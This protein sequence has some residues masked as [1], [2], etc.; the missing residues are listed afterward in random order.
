[1]IVQLRGGLELESLLIN[2]IKNNMN[3]V[4]TGSSLILKFIIG[5]T[6]LTTSKNEY[7]EIDRHSEQS[8]IGFKDS[9]K[10][11]SKSHDILRPD[12]FLQ[13]LEITFALIGNDTFLYGP[14]FNMVN[15]Y[16]ICSPMVQFRLPNDSFI[17][18]S[19]Q[20][21]NIIRNNRLTIEKMILKDDIF[22]FISVVTYI[23]VDS[24]DEY[25]QIDSSYF[26]ILTK[27]N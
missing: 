24:K 19:E 20:F 18:T 14:Y 6:F 9:I 15:K 3:V 12:S 2:L 21:E 5:I 27:R 26:Y 25:N 7:F 23:K 11:I 13:K 17:Q 16:S 22:Y 10:A 1:M 8:W 4:L